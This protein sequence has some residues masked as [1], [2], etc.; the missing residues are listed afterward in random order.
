[1]GLANNHVS[2]L[3]NGSSYPMTADYDLLGDP[4]LGP[5]RTFVLML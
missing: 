5:Q 3:G 1:M 2:K 4:G